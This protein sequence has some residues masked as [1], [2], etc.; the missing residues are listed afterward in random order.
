[1]T[2]VDFIGYLISMLSFTQMEHHFLS[3]KSWKRWSN[4]LFWLVFCWGLKNKSFKNFPQVGKM[5][6]LRLIF[7]TEFWMEHGFFSNNTFS[8]K[9][10]TLDRILNVNFQF[11]TKKVNFAE[12]HG[13]FWG[14]FIFLLIVYHNW[15]MSLKVK[16]EQ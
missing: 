12:K 6:F 10:K 15:A 5:C 13:F 14:G 11:S 4:G 7:G 1:M 8:L 3:I 16:E 9:Q 2:R